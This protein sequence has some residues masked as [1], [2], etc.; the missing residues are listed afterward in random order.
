MRPRP[1][2]KKNGKVKELIWLL[3]KKFPI[4]SLSLRHL[5]HHPPSKRYHMRHGR[6]HPHL[7]RPRKPRRPVRIDLPR[8]SQIIPGGRQSLVRELT[9]DRV[10]VRGREVV[11]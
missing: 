2:E 4:S 8:R 9:V 1:Q 10:P 3:Q 7:N 6:T 11:P 5:F